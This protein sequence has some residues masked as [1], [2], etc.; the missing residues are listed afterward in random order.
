MQTTILF[1]IH[2]KQNSH[3]SSS[4]NRGISLEDVGCCKQLVQHHRNVSW[5]D[6]RL[7]QCPEHDHSHL[8]PNASSNDALLVVP[9][10]HE[11]VHR[12]TPLIVEPL[13][14]DASQH[15]LLPQCSSVRPHN[16]PNP[17][18]MHPFLLVLDE[19][20][21]HD[22]F[23]ASVKNLRALMRLHHKVPVVP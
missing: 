15:V 11:V 4:S 17:N 8:Q 23:D 7:G 9:S 6:A 20:S 5:F 2:T 19:K 21:S 16:N 14:S 22:P 10:P 3:G 12:R 13:Q 18:N 1:S